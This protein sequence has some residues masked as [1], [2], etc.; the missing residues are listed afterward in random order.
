MK[1]LWRK[2]ALL[3]KRNRFRAE[4][5]EEM[6]FHRAQAEEQ[7]VAEGGECASSAQRGKATIWQ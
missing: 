3:L 5:E 2:L 7:F 4:L 1:A 6:A